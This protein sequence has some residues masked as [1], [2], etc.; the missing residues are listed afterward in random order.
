M[1][2]I[3]FICICIYNV[4][5]PYD[6]LS[7]TIETSTYRQRG[8]DQSEYPRINNAYETEPSVNHEDDINNVYRGNYNSEGIQAAAKPGFKQ[9][10][11]TA[12]FP[13]DKKRSGYNSSSST[14][15]SSRC[16]TTLSDRSCQS[17]PSSVSSVRS[18]PE[19]YPAQK[20]YHYG[21]QS[22][23]PREA[24]PSW[25]PR[26]SVPVPSSFTNKRNDTASD[27][28]SSHKSD[29]EPLTVR[30][31]KKR[32]VNDSCDNSPDSDSSSSS[33]STSS[34]SSSSPKQA[35]DITSSHL[36]ELFDEMKHVILNR[37]KESEEKVMKRF[38]D[39]LKEKICDAPDAENPGEAGEIVDA[40]D[41]KDTR[42]ARETIDAPD[43]ENSREAGEIVDAQDAKDAQVA[44][45]TIDAPDAENPGEANESIDAS[46]A[47]NTREAN[48]SI[49]AQDKEDTEA[50]IFVDTL[51]AVDF[52]LD[53]EYEGV[54][55]V[56]ES[57][58]VF[59]N[60]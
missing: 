56:H 60:N 40:Q 54:G 28:E 47:E 17:T 59:N 51:G 26:E 32:R 36:V 41:A 42:V 39:I 53:E 15:S 55:V 45:E 11:N 48:E 16:P 9:S 1:L 37:F 19:V 50:N 57:L 4:Y 35:L 7:Y 43:A 27:S 38:E 58:Q 34:L 44:R 52:Y 13:L 6:F 29:T 12:F 30:T 24:V 49:D 31:K 46:G 8:N 25:S 2:I 5:I 33:R 22:S 23:S 20:F 14:S 18:T 21:H 3:P 10:R